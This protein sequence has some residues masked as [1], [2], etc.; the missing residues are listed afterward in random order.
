MRVK[1]R[2]LA[3]VMAVVSI[4]FL[5]VVSTAETRKLAAPIYPGA[6]PALLAEGV[7]AADYYTATFG[8]VKALDCQGTVASR[9]FVGKVLTAEEAKQAGIS[10]GPWCFL[11]RDPIDKVKFFYDKSVG[12][13][14][15]IQGEKGVH[16]FE[17]F[18]ERAWFKG[19]Y[20][21][22]FGYRGVSVHA[23]PAPPVKSKYP[24]PASNKDDSWQGQ[25]DYKFYAQFTHLSLFMDA[26]DWFGDPRKKRKPAELDAMAKKYGHLE[27]AF[28]QRKGP[29]MKPEDKT[30]GEYYGKL[31]GERQQAAMMAP[32]SGRMQLNKA[33][34]QAGAPDSSKEDAEFNRVMQQNPELARRYVALTQ[35]V[36]SLMQQGKFDEADA[37]L[38]EIDALE[39]SN[40]ELAALANKEQGRQDSLQK[41]G[42]AQEDAIDAAANKQLD[43]ALW[44][45]AMEYIQTVDKEDYYTLIVIDNALAGTEKDYSRDQALIAKETDGLIHQQDLRLWGIQYKQS[46]GGTAQPAASQPSAPSVQNSGTTQQTVPEEK[47]GELGEAAKKGLNVLK[48]WF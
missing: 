38:D 45:T 36:S 1:T 5:A 12:A 8:G 2:L 33:N 23:L 11:T 46:R 22:G 32:L 27:S 44:G 6:V 19:E 15:P 31:Q 34:A 47:K 39:Q 28:F 18:A 24:V 21:D 35:K 17:V 43:E 25:E 48:K 14:Q 7:Q 37:V 4:F 41:A 30:L 29:E 9:D 26:V 3:V 16:G 13:M 10:V 40:P 42:Q 20:S